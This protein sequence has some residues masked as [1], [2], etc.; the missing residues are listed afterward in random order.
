MKNGQK[1]PKIEKKRFLEKKW[2]FIC[3]LLLKTFEKDDAEI[4]LEIFC[5]NIFF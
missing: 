5:E 2:T 3:I 1:C 4:L